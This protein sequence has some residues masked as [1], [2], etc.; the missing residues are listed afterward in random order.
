MI[1]GNLSVFQNILF[2]IACLSMIVLVAYLICHYSG[3][4]STKKGLS[5]DFDNPDEDF[6]D[7]GKF[8]VN[9]FTLKGSIFFVAVGSSFGFLFSLFFAV[10]L[11]LVLGAALGAGACIAIAFI[12]REPRITA[13]TVAIVSENIPE[14]AT[15]SGKVIALCDGVEFAAITNGKAIKKGKRVVVSEHLGNQVL[16]K[17]CKRLTKWK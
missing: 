4:A 14:N 16:V 10:W 3:Y 1:F 15:G 17:K 9:A 7:A 11:A 5:D 2:L 12:D 6:E 8:V 13:G